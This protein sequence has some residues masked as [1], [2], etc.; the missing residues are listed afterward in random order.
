MYNSGGRYLVSAINHNTY[1]YPIEILCI[2]ESNKAYKIQ[3]IDTDKPPMWILKTAYIN[4][5]EEL[6]HE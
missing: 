5:I 3:F 4:I 2:N 1:I 6:N